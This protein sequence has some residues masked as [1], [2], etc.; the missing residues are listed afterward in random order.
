VLNLIADL[1]LTW[2]NRGSRS[3]TLSA[4]K[5]KRVTITDF[6][7][8]LNDPSQSEVG[9]QSARTLSQ[10]VEHECIIDT[11]LDW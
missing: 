7:E 6:V 10:L 8:V 5:D 3:L 2:L 11:K 4:G 9:I 1:F